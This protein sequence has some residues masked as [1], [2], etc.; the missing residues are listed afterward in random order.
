MIRGSYNL[1]Y[2]H[3]F[4]LGVPLDYAKALMFYDRARLSFPS[5]VAD[6]DQ[7]LNG[8][9][10]QLLIS[11]VKVRYVWIYEIYGVARGQ[12]FCF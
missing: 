11:I 3:E 1:G 2:M 5:A 6:V 12:P 7:N 4:G 10:I 9:P 8:M